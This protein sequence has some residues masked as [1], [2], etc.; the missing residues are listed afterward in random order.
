MNQLTK[1]KIR[2]KCFLEDGKFLWFIPDLSGVLCKYN[3]DSGEVV[4]I[5]ELPCMGSYI[6]I[7]RHE[8][9]LVLVPLSAEEILIFDMDQEVFCRIKLPESDE[10]YLS[11]RKFFQGFAVN[12][13]VYLVPGGYPYILKVDLDNFDVARSENVFRMCRSFLAVTGVKWAITASAWD[14]NNA[15]YFG[16]GNE[17]GYICLGRLDLDTLCFSVKRAQYAESLI[18]AMICYQDNIFFYSADWKI[19]V[20]NRDLDEIK[21]ISESIMYDYQSPEEIYIVDTFVQDGEILFVR[22]LGLDM[23]VLNLQDEYL[24]SKRK[25]VEDSI[26]YASRTQYGYFIQPDQEGYF[27]YINKEGVI[28]KTFQIRK[29]ILQDYIQKIIADGNHMVYENKVCQLPEWSY[30]ISGESFSMSDI[31]NCGEEVYQHIAKS[32]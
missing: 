30:S 21:V 17:K 6:A 4:L 15:L 29:A 12:N 16:I 20:M 19:I 28:K 1:L 13:I 2:M 10:V 24:V 27:Y 25:L 31:K 8:R 7:I 9:Q 18:K 11:D 23:V 22:A 26:Q 32:L 3:L 5:Y 14:G